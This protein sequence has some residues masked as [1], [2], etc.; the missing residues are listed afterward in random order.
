MSQRIPGLSQPDMIALWKEFVRRSFVRTRF[1]TTFNGV[2]RVVYRDGGRLLV[3]DEYHGDLEV[4]AFQA[5]P[6]EAEHLGSQEID[7]VF[8]LPPGG[9]RPIVRQTRL[10]QFHRGGKHKFV[11]SGSL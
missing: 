4:L 5:R 1:Q 10:G 8:D 9:G 2:T 7:V 3:L 6:G 11:L